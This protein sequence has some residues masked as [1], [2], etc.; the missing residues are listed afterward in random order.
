MVNHRRRP[1]LRR[2]HLQRVED[3][4]G[5]QRRAHGPAH[6]PATEHVEHNR[7]VEEGRPRRHVGDVGHPELIRRRRPEVPPHEIGGEPLRSAEGRAGARPPMHAH[8]A[9][10]PHQAP[11]ALA[12]DAATRFLTQIL[13]E[14][15]PPVRAVG[16]RM[17]ELQ[18]RHEH[19]VLLRPLRRAASAPRVEPTRGDP[20]H[21]TERRDRALTER[22]HNCVS[23]TDLRVSLEIEPDDAPNNSLSRSAIRVDYAR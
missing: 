1:A 18:L 4:V 7:E 20:E 16:A 5:L 10:A 15:R 22:A 13:P 17:K 23:F 19:R 6:D 2:R 3:Q 12:A 8:Q 21:A 14:A 11:H 9:R